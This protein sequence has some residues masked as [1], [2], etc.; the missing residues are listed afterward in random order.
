MIHTLVLSKA[1]RKEIEKQARAAFPR[2]CCGLLE[3]TLQDNSAVTTAVHPTRNLAAEADRFE[4]D[5]AEHIRLLRAAR[6]NGRTI[7]G[8]YHSHPNGRPEPSARDRENGSDEEFV[9][10]VAAVTV[11]RVELRGFVF[12]EDAFQPVTL[13]QA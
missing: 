9:W 6:D 12:A 5:P 8:C 1:S 10:L 2:E 4:I 13:A 7:V 3:G 11:E